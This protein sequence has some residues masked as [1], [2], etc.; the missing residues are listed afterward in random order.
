[1]FATGCELNIILKDSTQKFLIR[2]FFSDR[3]DPVRR[4]AAECAHERHHA[5]LLL[6][7][8]NP[9]QRNLARYGAQL[10]SR[11]L[12]LLCRDY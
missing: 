10:V 1:M 8:M 11:L 4:N 9:V 7:S 12:R 2:A 3:K 6:F 5:V